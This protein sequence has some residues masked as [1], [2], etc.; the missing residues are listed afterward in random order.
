[1]SDTFEGT[2]PH[3]SDRYITREIAGEILT[4]G[5][6]VELTT[7][8]Q[9]VKKP[10]TSPGNKP[11]GVCITSAALGKSVSVL[12]RGRVRAKAYGTITVGDCIT[13]GPGGTIQTRA[14]ISATDLTGTSAAIAAILNTE[15]SIMGICEIG[16]A[17]GA[18]AVIF[19]T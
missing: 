7:A 16:A 15:R 4:M 6:V 9:T 17:S 14:A 5:Q 8:D 12:W 18:S 19:L 2:N 11:S 3:I 1:M 13:S 10:T